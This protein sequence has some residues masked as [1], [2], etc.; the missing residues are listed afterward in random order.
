MTA[1]P[2]PRGVSRRLSRPRCA[3][4]P[5]RQALTAAASGLAWSAG[6]SALLRALPRWSRLERSNFH[7]RT[8]S[9]RGGIATA[10]GATTAAGRAG[11]LA[12]PSALTGRP[13]AAAVIAASAGAT[14]GLIDDL[15]A[16]AHDGQAP[17]KGLAGH[18]G[19][20][21]QGRVTTGALKIAIIGSGALVAGA[22]LARHRAPAA[23]APR[24]RALVA[25]AAVSAIVIGAWAN[26][27]NL[28]DLRPGRALKASALI[29][30]PLLAWPGRAAAPTRVLAAGALGVAVASA[31]EDL[32]E[33]T[34]LGD[35][36]ANSLGGLVGAAL[37]AA[38]SRAFRH[39]AAVTGVAL[40]LASERVSFSRVIDSTPALAALDALGRRDR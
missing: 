17:A 22:L 34:M 13:G 2:L 14:A 25:D 8:V 1:A 9:L 28:L 24:P 33:R 3:A 40:I 4:S 18:L 10:I 35:T 7:G 30:A 36:G 32:G 19:A 29:S 6:A 31:P 12:R 38:P 20:L 39:G 27:H 15:D 23:P 5:A 16:G 37:A 26:V 21:S 11:A